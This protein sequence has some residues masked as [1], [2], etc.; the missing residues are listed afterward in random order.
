LEKLYYK[1]VR[2]PKASFPE[3]GLNAGHAKGGIRH[4]DLQNHLGCRLLEKT[5]ET[6]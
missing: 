2:R 6:L 3:E 5:D 1:S 4:D